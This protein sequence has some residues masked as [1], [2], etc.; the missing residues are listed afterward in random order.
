MCVG[1]WDVVVEEALEVMERPVGLVL[2][3]S[4]V[5]GLVVHE[6]RSATETKARGGRF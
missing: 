3:G 6:G 4:R 2:L 5:W 1:M